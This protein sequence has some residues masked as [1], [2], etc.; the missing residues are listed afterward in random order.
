[1]V[2]T[3]I[4][5]R[6]VRGLL[7]IFHSIQLLPLAAGCPGVVLLAAGM[8]RSGSLHGC[9]LKEEATRYELCANVLLS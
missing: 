1:M 9:D 2:L 6:A 7:T 4:F 3:Q 8:L 5:Q